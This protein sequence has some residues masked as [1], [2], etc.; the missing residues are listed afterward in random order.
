M[1]IHRCG[2][3]SGALG[4]LAF[5]IL[6]VAVAA[7]LALLTSCAQ[8]IPVAATTPQAADA[9]PKRDQSPSPRIWSWPERSWPLY[10]TLSADLSACQ[11]AATFGALAF[12]ESYTA[13]NLFADPIIV[14][15]L[16]AMSP[17][18]GIHVHQLVGEHPRVKGLAS[19]AW[20]NEEERIVYGVD[21]GLLTCSWRHAA[22]E[23]GHALGL[24]HSPDHRALMHW[25]ADD[26]AY[27]MHPA[28]LFDVAAAP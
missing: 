3:C 12:W 5:V 8:T 1:T 9:E 7:A 11:L 19:A 2:N 23:I 25:L 17:P 4:K 20:L 10:V 24:G 15:Q 13:R 26:T 22:H 14:Q 21:V 27:L 18:Y 16:S 28:E 6:A